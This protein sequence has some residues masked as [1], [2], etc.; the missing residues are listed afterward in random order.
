MS[1]GGQQRKMACALEWKYFVNSSAASWF[2]KQIRVFNIFGL[3]LSNFL[4]VFLE[5]TVLPQC[6]HFTHTFHVQIK[7]SM[8]ILK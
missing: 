4:S 1:V 5:L 7:H 3:S 6:L 2:R 8:K